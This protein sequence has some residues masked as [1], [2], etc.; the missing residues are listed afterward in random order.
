MG[1]WVGAGER[2][3]AGRVQYTGEAA[4]VWPLRRSSP[5]FFPAATAAPLDSS[6]L[7]LGRSLHIPSQASPRISTW[8]NR[9][10]APLWRAS[11]MAAGMRRIR[12]PK[13]PMTDS[14]AGIC[15]SGIER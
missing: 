13:H 12:P 5:A 2:Q 4:P 6:T 1:G 3:S 7:S 11:F 8:S 14:A 15:S 9:S 10:I